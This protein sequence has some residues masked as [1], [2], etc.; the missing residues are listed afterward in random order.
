MTQRVKT[1]GTR[2]MAAVAVLLLLPIAG[3]DI[4]EAAVSVR[5]NDACASGG[6]C[7][8]PGDICG[9]G[10]GE[11]EFHRYFAGSGC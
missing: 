9:D 11:I 1:L 4:G 3:V 7:F 2:I 5:V 6:C 10:G 8:S